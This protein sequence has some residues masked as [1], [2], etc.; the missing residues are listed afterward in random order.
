[1]ILQI[2]VG[3]MP[4]YL[5]H[6]HTA[7]WLIAA[8]NIRD[9]LEVFQLVPIIHLLSLSRKYYLLLSNSL[10]F[11]LLEIILDQEL[12]TRDYS[13]FFGEESKYLESSTLVWNLW[14]WVIFVWIVWL[15]LGRLA[16]R[17]AVVPLFVDMQ[18]FHALLRGVYAHWLT[19]F[20]LNEIIH[21]N[22]VVFKPLV[23]ID[24]RNEENI[25]LNVSHLNKTQL[26]IGV[27]VLL[28]WDLGR[29]G[30]F[31]GD[32][33]LFSE[34]KVSHF[35]ELHLSELVLWLDKLDLVFLTHLGNFAFTLENCF[36]FIFCLGDKKVWFLEK[37]PLFTV[38]ALLIV[39]FVILTDDS[40]NEALELLCTLVWNQSHL[41]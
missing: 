23:L 26:D 16:N 36:H 31:I 10:H 41:G 25:W 38:G 22:S 35:L 14:W 2:N 32:L 21:Q 33:V 9:R 28:L 29:L 11:A 40:K 30:T 27:E 18:A 24:K 17:E 7:F 15:D 12:F 19:H 5:K 3:Y 1:M 4:L 37:R 39:Y 6:E 8:V 34:L 20:L 13:N